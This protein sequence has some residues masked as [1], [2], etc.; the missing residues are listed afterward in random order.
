MAVRLRLGF[1]RMSIWSAV[2]VVATIW[3]YFVAVLIPV[4]RRWI[5]WGWD[6]ERMKAQ[7]EY[8]SAVA[9]FLIVLV[10]VIAFSPRHCRECDSRL[11]R[12]TA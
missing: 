11:P 12:F 5:E 8:I 9:V 6:W 2:A 4:R 7:I 3:T 1:I 10:A